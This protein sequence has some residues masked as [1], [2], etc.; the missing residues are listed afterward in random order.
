M[1]K[2]FIKPLAEKT[3]LPKH[4]IL[5][6]YT[7]YMRNIQGNKGINISNE[8][9]DNLIILDACRF[10]IFEQISTIPGNLN[11]KVSKGSATMEFVQKNFT[12]KHHDI[13][14]VTAN[15]TVDKHLQTDQFHAIV[16]AWDT[17]WNEKKGTVLP[18][19]MAEVTLDTYK[20]YPNKRIIS[21]FIQPHQPFIGEIGDKIYQS[22]EFGSTLRGHRDTALGDSPDWS[23]YGKNVYTGL[24]DGKIDPELI[25][26]GYKEN[27]EL[28][29]PYVEK[30]C[31]QMDGLSVVSSDHGNIFSQPKYQYLTK[32]PRLAVSAA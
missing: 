14:Y 5:S 18:S 19:D 7:Y 16:R 28:T 9:W 15:P 6:L 25:W 29:L 27:L 10:D 12:D 21:H 31:R 8:D 4:P 1:Y 23:R 17:H 30:L 22:S 20:K 26:R 24:F 11:R 32:H 13:V 3:I 2:K